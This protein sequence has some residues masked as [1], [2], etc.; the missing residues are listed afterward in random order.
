MQPSSIR[1][2]GTVSFETLDQKIL[3]GIGAVA[4][5]GLV[6]VGLLVASLK[7]LPGVRDKFHV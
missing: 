5:I 4:L 7:F 6:A 1:R 3:R 2:P